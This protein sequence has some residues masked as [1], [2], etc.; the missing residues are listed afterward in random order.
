MPGIRR[1]RYAPKPT[2]HE[3]RAIEAIEAALAYEFAHVASSEEIDEVVDAAQADLSWVSRRSH[4]PRL[5]EVEARAAL[6][7][8]RVPRR[9]RPADARALVPAEHLHRRRLGPSARP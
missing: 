6:T 3:A 8:R 9:H 1:S 5:V 2:A 7:D 4:V